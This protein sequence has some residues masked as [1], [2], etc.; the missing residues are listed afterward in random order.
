MSADRIQ[1][2]IPLL[3]SVVQELEDA[4]PGRSFTPDGH[5]VGSIGEVIAADRYGLTLNTAS[6]EGHDAI[7]PDG[8]PVEIKATTGNGGIRVRG[9]SPMEGLHLIVLR[10][11]ATGEAET[12]YNGPAAPA[13][14][15]AGRIQT[16]GQ[17][18]ISLSKLGKLQAQVATA[19]QLAAVS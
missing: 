5:M 16:N 3:Y 8:R 19:E 15:A 7:A 6:T 12:I 17:R 1:K 11:D 14:E 10:I 2:L 13:W 4:A 18:A 9:L